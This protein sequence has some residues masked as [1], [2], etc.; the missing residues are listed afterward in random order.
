MPCPD[1]KPIR[2]YLTAEE[3][4]CLN[5]M[6]AS[7]GRSASQFI[8]DICLGYQVRSFEHEEFKLELLKTRADLGRLGGLL[9]LALST[10]DRFCVDDQAGLRELLGQ[11]TQRQN[12][13]KAAVERL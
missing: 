13:I 11:I 10:P 8:R 6:A 1:K 9:K 12:E 4:E 3:H 2:S 7:A 5:R